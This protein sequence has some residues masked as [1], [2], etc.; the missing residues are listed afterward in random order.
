[1]FYIYLRTEVGPAIQTFHVV[2]VRYEHAHD[3]V[4]VLS[5]F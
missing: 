5:L 2:L 3:K 1:M 4:T